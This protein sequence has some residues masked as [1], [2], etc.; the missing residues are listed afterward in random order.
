VNRRLLEEIEGNRMR[1]QTLRLERRYLYEACQQAGLSLHSPET[2]SAEC[3]AS[4]TQATSA[5]SSIV[6]YFSHFSLL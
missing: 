6:L 3:F 4:L 1:L 2:F 5:A